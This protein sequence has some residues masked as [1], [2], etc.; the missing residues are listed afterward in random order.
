LVAAAGA[1][2]AVGSAAGSAAASGLDVNELDFADLEKSAPDP[3]AL[4]KSVIEAAGY[5]LVENGDVFTV[6]VPIGALRKQVVTIRF[7]R[8]DDDGDKLV[9]FSSVCGPATSNNAM[10][11]LR[12]NTR[13]PHGAFAVE[14]TD[15]GEQIV[16][17]ANHLAATTDVLEVTRTLNAVAW[18]ADKVE[19]KLTKGDKN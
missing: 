7:D 1:G 5:T 16:V 6:T 15:S 17:Q 10:A 2:A 19:E 14:K 9:S 8:T 11:L 4:V 3:K 13:M 18:Q 12:Y